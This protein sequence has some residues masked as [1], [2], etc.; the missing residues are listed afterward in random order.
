MSKNLIWFCRTSD[1]S[2]LSRITDTVIPLLQSKFNITLLSNKTNLSGVKNVVIGSDANYITYKNFIGEK[3][4]TDDNVR[5]MLNMKYV[6]IQIVDLIFDN[7]YDYLLICN[8]IYEVDWFVKILSNSETYL[9]NKSG[10]KT[11]LIV[12]SPLDY[13]PT[14]KVIEN[15]IKADLFLTMTPVMVEEIISVSGIDPA[16]IYSVGHGSNI[17]NKLEDIDRLSAIKYIN[18]MRAKGLVV[19]KQ[20]IQ[21]SDIIIL[22]AN[23]YGPLKDEE[24]SVVNTPGTRKRLDITIKSFIKLLEQFPSVKLWIHT[25]LESFFKMLAIENIS[26]ADI[27]NSLIFSRNKLSSIELSYIYRVCQIS[28]QTSTGEGWSLTNLESAMYGSLQVVPDFLACGYHF[29]K[30]R[31]ILIPVSRKTI[32]NEG[33]LDVTIGEVSIE[34]TTAAVIKAINILGSDE[35]LNIINNAKDYAKSYTWE[36]VAENLEHLINGL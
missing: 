19:C 32:Q 11:K 2:S 4:I 13:I 36:N 34:D 20:P 5:R 16:K 9:I 18:E 1:S 35:H 14:L 24:V 15:T 21:E 17:I 10:K 33:K 29:S 22:N 30:N 28:L 8:G 27:C 26:I 25:D 7:D 3:S 31:G 23:N 12:W 6:L